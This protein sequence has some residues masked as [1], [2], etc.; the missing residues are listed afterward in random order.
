MSGEYKS[1]SCL[2]QVFISPSLCSFSFSHD[3]PPQM[4]RSISPFTCCHTHT[5][6]IF[7]HYCS[8]PLPFSF[9]LLISPAVILLIVFLTVCASDVLSSTE[10][11]RLL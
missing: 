10:D 7:C 1:I 8:V 6:I 3:L 5:T 9:S 2:F 11:G 4:Q